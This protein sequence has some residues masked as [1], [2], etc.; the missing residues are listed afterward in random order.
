VRLRPLSLPACLALLASTADAQ[1]INRALWLGDDREGFQRDYRQDEE[2]FLDRA[3]YVDPAPW[4]AIDPAQLFAN[5]LSAAA[6]SVS[7]DELTVE[8]NADVRA[9]LGRG[10]TG[11]FHYL[12][13]EHQ[14]ARF[15]RFAF[16][17]DAALWRSAALFA[18][19][20]GTADKSRAD[21]A[22][23]LALSAGERSAHRLSLSLVDFPQGKSDEFDYVHQPYGLGLAGFVSDGAG[24]ALLYELGFQAPFEQ[25]DLETDERF[26]MQRT[27]GSIEV[28]A[29]LGE[30]ERL[31]LGL[32]GELTGKTLEPGSAATSP[33]SADIDKTRLRAEWWRSGEAGREFALGASYL[34]LDEDY[35]DA[36]DPG[37]AGR[38]RREELMLLARARFPLGGAWSL[39]PYVLGG[40]VDLETEGT[41]A[42]LDGDDFLGFQGKCGA[43]LRFDFSEFA[44]LRVDLSLELDEL[45]FGGG[46]V[47]LVASF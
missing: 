40:R 33:Q 6:G 35:G 19:V 21:L 3:A 45:A 5:R 22:L 44:S 34:Y 26:E 30:R 37:E 13:S 42:E 43:P 25:R 7:S 16:G 27:I 15:E 18:Q 20:E 14:S 8:A 32:D 39:E 38:T 10:V 11:R 23:G 47:Q 1:F 4:R 36:G 46:A 12:Q 28:R 24:R 29:P 31:V 41:Q 9:E 2:Y 17:L